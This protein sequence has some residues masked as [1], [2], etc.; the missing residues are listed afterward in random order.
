MYFYSHEYLLFRFPPPSLRYPPPPSLSSWS[1]SSLS[2]N[3]HPLPPLSSSLS[4]STLC[5]AAGGGLLS[6]GLLRMSSPSSSSYTASAAALD[7][8]GSI[9]TLIWTLIFFPS[10]SSPSIYGLLEVLEDSG[11]GVALCL[12]EYCPTEDLVLHQKSTPM[13]SQ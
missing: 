12:C 6:R 2:G 3:S 11:G 5:P 4:L 9:R 7:F 8:L 10:Y 13:A 1:L